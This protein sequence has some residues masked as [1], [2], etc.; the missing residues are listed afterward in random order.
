MTDY[1]RWQLRAQNLEGLDS[2]KARGL[3]RKCFFEAQKEA[4]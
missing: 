3:I 4:F 2:D 1:Q